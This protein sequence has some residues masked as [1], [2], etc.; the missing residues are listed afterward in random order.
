MK[1]IINRYKIN[2]NFAFVYLFLDKPVHKQNRLYYSMNSTQLT[3]MLWT[4]EKDIF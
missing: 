1:D 4:Y 2:F 3:E